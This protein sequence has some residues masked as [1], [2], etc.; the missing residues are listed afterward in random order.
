MTVRGEYTKAEKE[1]IAADNKEADTLVGWTEFADRFATKES[2]KGIALM[3]DP[4]NPLWHD[5]DYAA[6]T[7]WGDIIAIPTYLQGQWGFRLEHMASSVLKS[8]PELGYQHFW[9]VG[10]DWEFFKPIR[11]GDSFRIWRRRPQTKDMTPLDGKG[12][13]TFAR[14]LQDCDYINQ[15]DEL[16]CRLKFY[17]QR[18]FLPEAPKPHPM[19]EY[20]YTKEEVEFIVHTISEE[21][22]R[23]ANIR[24]WENV[25]IDE[26][27]K[28]V[29]LG[30]TNIQT[31][32]AVYG[33]MGTITRQA[34]KKYQLEAPLPDA[35]TLE[36]PLPDATTL[37]GGTYIFLKDPNTGRFHT[38]AGQHFSDRAAQAV[39]DP[40]AYIPGASSKFNM[41]RVV[42]NWMGDDGFVT[43]FNWRHPHRVYIGDTLI[44]RGKVI[45]KRVQNG[46]HLVDIVVWE[47]DMRGR[48]T[49]AATATVVLLSKEDPYPP[50]K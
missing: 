38:H 29:V 21:Q 50:I 22:V 8:P 7:R 47:Q 19:S 36:A 27:T 41:L 32:F 3:A 33:A 40:I 26:E 37:V 17:E 23:G 45:D 14:V 11:P 13:R 35:T 42:T 30:P 18:S 25:S 9:W 1:M 44:G 31:S 15:K 34:L 10:E 28:P 48:V 46:E 4:W 2:M 24:Y 12:P 43:K 39:G 6:R 16:V 20:G 49:G 5:E